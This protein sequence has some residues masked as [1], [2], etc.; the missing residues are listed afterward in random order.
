M[1][2]RV[3]ETSYRDSQS[4][5]PDK[6]RVVPKNLTRPGIKGQGFMGLGYSDKRDDLTL[7]KGIGPATHMQLNDL[8][9]TSFDQLSKLTNSQIDRIQRDYIVDRDIRG[10]DWASQTID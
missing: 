4:L 3:G 8:D 6:R 7:I 1:G 10:Q 5:Q 2:K 9:I